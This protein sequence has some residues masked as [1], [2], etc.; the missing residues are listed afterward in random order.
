MLGQPELIF[1]QGKRGTIASLFIVR[2]LGIERVVRGHVLLYHLLLIIAHTTPSPTD[3]MQV[4]AWE[5]N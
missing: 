1:I 2:V 5:I 3:T 4:H